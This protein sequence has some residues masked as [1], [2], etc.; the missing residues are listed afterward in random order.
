MISNE[1]VIAGDLRTS[2]EHALIDIEVG[3]NLVAQVISWERFPSIKRAL[4]MYRVVVSDAPITA[5]HKLVP[6]IDR[7]AKCRDVNSLAVGLLQSIDGHVY[8]AVTDVHMVN[9]PSSSRTDTLRHRVIDAEIGFAYPN[10][11]LLR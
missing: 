8:Q 11:Q 1:F 7:N 2:K 6:S 3:K 4:M 9:K 5:R 10:V